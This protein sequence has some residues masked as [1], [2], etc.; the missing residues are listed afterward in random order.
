MAKLDDASAES[1]E[2]AL[3]SAVGFSSTDRMAAAKTIDAIA[4]QCSLTTPQ[5]KALWDALAVRDPAAPPLTD[6][7]GNA[8]PDADLRD[9]ENVPLPTELLLFEADP[10]ARL[11]TLAYRSA[12]EDYV[13]AEVLPY[14]PD[15][16]ADH[17][18]TKIAYEVPLTR[19]FYKYLPPRLLAEIDAE[20][21]ALETEIQRLLAEVTE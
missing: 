12:V 13:T 16:W 11:A 19:H 14:V 7:K 3:R 15:A 18:K 1:L 21:K 2:A 20:I 6:K 10:S 5:T 4:K 9:G 17:D 8:E